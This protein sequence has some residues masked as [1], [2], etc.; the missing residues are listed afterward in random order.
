M[1]L[2]VLRP[3][4]VA[5]LSLFAITSCVKDDDYEIPDPNAK[6]VLPT[7]NGSV[8]SFATVVAKATNSVVTYTADEAIEGYVI[9]SDEGGNFY[10]KIYIEN[11]D[12]TQA[13]SVAINKSGLYNDF[14]V[15]AKVQLR[16]KDLSIHKANGGVEFGYGTYNNNGVGQMSEAIYKNHLYDMGGERKTVAQLAKADTSIEALKVDG[17]INQ[18]LTLKE[19]EF[20]SAAIGKNFHLVANDKQNGTNHTLQD[21]NGKTIPFRT[22]KYAKFKNEKVPAGKLN[23][24]GV[25][26][27]YIAKNGNE[28]WQFMISNLADIQVIGGVA[29]GTQTSTQTSTT[30][31]P[32]E[33]NTATVANFV[34]GKKVALHGNITYK[35][36]KSY[37]VFGDNTEIQLFTK[38]FRGISTENKTKLKTNGQEVTVTG[39]FKKHGTT[40]E[41]EYEKESDLVFGT[42][43]A[44]QPPATVVELNVANATVAD[45][46]N[47]IGK[48]VKLTGTI[49]VKTN[50]SYI[51]FSDGTEILLYVKNY[52]G[53]S[54]S[55]RDKM[56][57]GAKVSIKGEFSE[58]GKKKT[59]QLTYTSE[60][61]VEFK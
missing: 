52:S 23:V 42:H 34:E 40:L 48:T 12:K 33:A 20:S 19:V 13:V 39:V 28:S 30:A 14:P 35:S 49:T 22:S 17:N 57:Q 4:A 7:F 54:Q 45:F 59:K 60:G 9:S 32:L 26:T 25:L 47:N 55:F 51:V 61:D 11:E 37:I 8:V 43:N 16:L 18:L 56:V 31:E 46:N 27:K 2:N 3:M 1:K 24:T 53:L 36:G 15:G 50:K 44:P 5:L 6:K 41:I 21:A 38:D 58:F 10:K 29:T